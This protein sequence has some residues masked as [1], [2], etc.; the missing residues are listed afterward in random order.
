[1]IL[2][3]YSQISIATVMVHMAMG[4]K[5][6]EPL[7]RHM[8]LNS[9]RMYNKQFKEKYGRMVLC[10]D[11][12]G[13]WRKE[14]F[15]LYKSKRHTDRDDDEKDWDAIFSS[16]NKIQKEIS[17]TFCYQCMRVWGAE[18]DDIIAVLC[19]EYGKT[20]K[21]MI[22][23]GDK[24]FKQLHTDNIQQWSP[25]TKNLV[26]CQDP[27]AFLRE[28]ILAGDKSDG[29]PNVLSSDNCIV[30]GLRQSPLT[31]RKKDLFRGVNFSGLS[32]EHRRNYERNEQL[33]D[34]SK[35]PEQVSDKIL[36]DF[37]SSLSQTPTDFS[38]VFNYMVENRLTKL[39]DCIE[40]FKPKEY[41]A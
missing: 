16:L 34:L 36:E 7:I 38:R 35:I 39:L 12:G 10:C 21:I 28:H 24:D 27:Q 5:F 25:K 4:G 41:T 17:K 9:L 37:R 31:P 32:E 29:I 13:N 6:E 3:D 2:V 30:D 19:R 20:E 33:I 15:P 1:M 40:D 18:A 23:S 22:V 8:I 11:S 26:Q 14:V